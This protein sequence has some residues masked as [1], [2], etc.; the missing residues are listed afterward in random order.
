VSSKLPTPEINPQDMVT[1]WAIALDPR[2]RKI[3][4]VYRKDFTPGGQPAGYGETNATAS[5][6]YMGAKTIDD[7]ARWIANHWP[8]LTN[9]RLEFGSTETILWAT[10]SN[11]YRSRFRMLLA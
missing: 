1:D 9:I 7:Y 2:N 3:R 6:Q 11:G 10:E 4:A 8:Q 5:L